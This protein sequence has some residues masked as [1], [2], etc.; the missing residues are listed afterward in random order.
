MPAYGVAQAGGVLTCLIPGDR[1]ELFS[2]LETP[3]AGLKS[4]AFSRGF[5]PGAY[6]AGMVF[7]IIFA[8]APTATVL[9]QGSNADVDGDYVT[10]ATVAFPLAPVSNVGYYS[11]LGQWAFYRAILSVTSAGGMPAIIVQR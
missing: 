3:A 6:P 5:G 7:Q 4:V 8:S 2:G 9:I 11:D 1:Y 10:L